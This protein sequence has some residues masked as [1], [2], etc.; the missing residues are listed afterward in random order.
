MITLVAGIICRRRP[1]PGQ[2]A[3]PRLVPYRHIVTST[4]VRLKRGREHDHRTNPRTVRGA[5]D[6][7][8]PGPL[9][10]VL[11]RRAGAAARAS[12]RYAAGRVLLG[13][14][15]RQGHARP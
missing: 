7:Q 9:D 1:Q 3:N 13:A 8:R 15:V 12:Y 11:P 4:S 5:P 10:R 14:V 2:P 6:G